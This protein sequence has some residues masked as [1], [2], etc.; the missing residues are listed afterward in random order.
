M[1]VNQELYKKFIYA[2]D[3][4]IQIFKEKIKSIF[5]EEPILIHVD[6]HEEEYLGQKMIIGKYDFIIH[7]KERECLYYDIVES[8]CVVEVEK[9]S[10]EY[11]EE[12]DEIIEKAL[13]KCISDEVEEFDMENND[14]QF[15]LVYKDTD[16]EIEYVIDFYD[17]HFK[18]C[19]YDALKTKITVPFTE[20]MLTKIN[21]QELREILEIYVLSFVNRIKTF[22]EALKHILQYFSDP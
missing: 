9:L 12:E 17:D 4:F 15:N 16:I 1:N 7:I 13:E 5:N 21:D 20:Y 2:E 3:L 14:Q 11:E 10:R 18:R 8:I 6:S 22:Y 19:F